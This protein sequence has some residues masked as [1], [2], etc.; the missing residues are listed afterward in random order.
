MRPVG[1]DERDNRRITVENASEAAT[2]GC[3]VIATPAAM[4]AR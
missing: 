4:Q 1:L 2:E 3:L